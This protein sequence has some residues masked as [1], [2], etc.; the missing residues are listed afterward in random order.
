MSTEG[1]RYGKRRRS[2]W[3]RGENI[4]K[5]IGLVGPPLRGVKKKKCYIAEKWEGELA[6]EIEEK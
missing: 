5:L 1:G 3:G 2:R 4:A 6:G